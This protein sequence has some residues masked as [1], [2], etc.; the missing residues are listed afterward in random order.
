MYNAA[1]IKA[2]QSLG[3]AVHFTLD[4]GPNTPDVPLTQI[5]R[6]LVSYDWDIGT[7]IEQMRS[8][9][10]IVAYTIQ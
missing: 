3:M 9:R 5:R 4:D 8:P 6:L 1:L 7:M 2:S 10:R